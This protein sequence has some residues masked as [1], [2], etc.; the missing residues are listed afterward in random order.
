MILVI[1]ESNA[2][3]QGNILH[4]NTIVILTT[5]KCAQSD[6]IVLR[7]QIVGMYVRKGFFAANR[8]VGCDN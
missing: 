1:V 2:R 6:H 3:K 7:I 4:I 8:A 5:I